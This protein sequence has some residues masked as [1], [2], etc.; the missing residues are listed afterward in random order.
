M[1]V[2]GYTAKTLATKLRCAERLFYRDPRKRGFRRD[3]LADIAN[4]LDSTTLRAHAES[5]IF[6]DEVR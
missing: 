2:R 3:T 4:T 1:S 6:W 5:D